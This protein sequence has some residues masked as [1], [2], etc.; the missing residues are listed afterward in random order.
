MLFNITNGTNGQRIEVVL[1]QD[2][3][4]N[5][6][7]LRGCEFAFFHRYAIANAVDYR[8]QSG[9]LAVPLAQ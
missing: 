6:I 5:R 1:T 4:G 9:R 3:T 2:G 7:I 8:K